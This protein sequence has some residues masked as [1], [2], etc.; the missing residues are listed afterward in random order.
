[1][2]MTSLKYPLI[3]V[4][5]RAGA[6]KDTVCRMACDHLLAYR[7][8]NPVRKHGITLSLATPLKEA[9]LEIFGRAYGVERESFF[10]SQA[11]KN[12][13]IP[14]LNHSG[15]EI[16]QWVGTEGFRAM[17]PEV[18][19][20]YLLETAALEFQGWRPATAVFVSDVRFPDEAALIQS[21]GGVIVKVIRPS[22]E[23]TATSGIASHASEAL[24]SQIKSDYEIN[25]HDGPLESLDEL[26][27]GMLVHYGLLS[28]KR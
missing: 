8:T 18:W 24:F 3:G 28:P 4:S 15:R 20:K 16:L 26:V 25:N 13:I 23:N 6:G 21:A 12:A 1:M 10:G 17:A 27:Y 5:G 22:L 7:G 9:C 19:G 2:A 11:Q 14:G